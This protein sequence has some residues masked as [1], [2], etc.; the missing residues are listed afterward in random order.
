MVQKGFAEAEDLM[1]EM[2]AAKAARDKA[3]AELADLEPVDN[4]LVLHPAALK[5]YAEQ[6]KLLRDQAGASLTQESQDA[7]N[8]SGR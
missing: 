6:I 3:Q 1:E 7:A 8:G 2:K 4:V 5:K